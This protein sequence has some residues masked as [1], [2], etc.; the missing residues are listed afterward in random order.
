MTQIG[1]GRHATDAVYMNYSS[2][3]CRVGGSRIYIRHGLQHVSRVGVYLHDF[4]STLSVS[5]CTIN[6]PQTN[7]RKTNTREDF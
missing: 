7:T 3:R 2:Q 6:K 1:Q 4:H 5:V